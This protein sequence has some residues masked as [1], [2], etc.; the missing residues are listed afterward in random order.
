MHPEALEVGTGAER[1]DQDRLR[2]QVEAIVRHWEAAQLF[3]DL[4]HP[5]GV[6]VAKA[7]QVE[8]SGRSVSPL[9]PESEKGCAFHDELVSIVGAGEAKQEPLDG[10]AAEDELEVLLPCVRQVQEPLTRRGANVP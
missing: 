1:L 2:R 6:F 5:R 9:A 10:V 3:E 8:I 4:L 7:E